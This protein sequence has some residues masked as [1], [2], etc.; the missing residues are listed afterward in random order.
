MKCNFA[1][2]NVWNPDEGSTTRSI[3]GANEVFTSETGYL[4]GKSEV[5][6]RL[7]S[8]SILIYKYI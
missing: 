8:L 6:H 3:G 5:R 2:H 1:S 4:D 7:Q